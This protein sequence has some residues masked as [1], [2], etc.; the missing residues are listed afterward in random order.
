MS[1]TTGVDSNVASSTEAFSQNIPR[2]VHY[3]IM[4]SASESSCESGGRHSPPGGG[5]GGGLDGGG[6][7]GGGGESSCDDLAPKDSIS[8]SG[9]G[10]RQQRSAARRTRNMS[11]SMASEDHFVR[12]MG[13]V[14]TWV[15]FIYFHVIAQLKT[16]PLSQAVSE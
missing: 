1:S 10:S 16:S 4:S 12:W 14:C 6:A 3:Q 15:F 2:R 13:K 5:G 8:E 11:G 9:P 7:A